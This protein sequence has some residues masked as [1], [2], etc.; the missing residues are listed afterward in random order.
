MQQNDRVIVPSYRSWNDEDEPIMVSDEKHMKG[1]I[2]KLMAI[3]T[4]PGGIPMPN[5]DYLAWVVLDDPIG[6]QDVI[7]CKMSQLIK[8]EEESGQSKAR[9]KKRGKR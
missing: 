9:T 1:Y 6:I 3:S 5:S 2:S 4:G 8:L 7:Q